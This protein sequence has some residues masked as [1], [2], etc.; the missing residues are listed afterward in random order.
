MGRPSVT[1]VVVVMTQPMGHPWVAYGLEVLSHG[2]LMGRPCSYSTVPWV[3][4]M[5][6]IGLYCWP[7]GRPSLSYDAGT[8]MSGCLAVCLSSCSHHS[9]RLSSIFAVWVGRVG[10]ATS[11]TPGFVPRIATAVAC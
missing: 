9:A 8:L 1:H 2:S 7:T 10:D 6:V 5:S 3:V 4:H 11:K